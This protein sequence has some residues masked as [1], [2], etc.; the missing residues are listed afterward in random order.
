[1]QCC[2][3]V[4]QYLRQKGK[5]CNELATYIGTLVYNILFMPNAITSPRVYDGDFSESPWLKVAEK[6]YHV[7]LDQWW[8]QQQRFQIVFPWQVVG[9]TKEID[10][11]GFDEAHVRLY[12]HG[13]ITCELEQWRFWLEH[14]QWNR[15]WWAEYLLDILETNRWLFSESEFEML[16]RNIWGK[17]VEEYLCRP[18]NWFMNRHFY[19]RMIPVN[20]VIGVYSFDLFLALYTP[21]FLL[22]VSLIHKHTARI[23]LKEYS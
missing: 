23:A 1:M 22:G 12:W 9:I 3:K 15:E 18:N 16:I 17:N 5:A 13:W 20:I 19:Y 10:V 2:E 21:I 8:F 14:W 7:L 11:D 6:L 4:W